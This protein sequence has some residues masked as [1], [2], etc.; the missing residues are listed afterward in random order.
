MVRS[1]RSN[2]WGFPR[3]RG[4]GTAREAQAV[5]LCDRVGCERPGK[6]PAPKSPN[7]P[8][9]W[10]FCEEHAAEYNK[11]WD[12]FAGLTAEEAAE[13]EANERRDSSGYRE[14]AHYGWMGPGDGSRSRDEMRALEL[15]G[16]DPDASFEDAKKAWRKIAKETHP[17]VNP[18]NGDAAKAFQ[19]GQAAYDVLRVAEE[20]REWRG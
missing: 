13:R 16:L 20:R 10:M 18:G 14:S 5:R 8:D 15:F 17:D 19:A 11:G 1:S 12:Y 4:Y 6:C 3:W 2:D 7:N 9:R